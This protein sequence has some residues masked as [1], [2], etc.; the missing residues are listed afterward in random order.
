MNYVLTTPSPR[1]QITLPKK[2]RDKIKRLEP[3]KPLRVSTDGDRIVIEPVNDNPLVV[4]AKYT[5][6][7]SLKLMEKYEKSGKIYWTE[8]DDKHLARLRKKDNKYLHWEI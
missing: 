2:V 8:E 1:W 4:K 7:E 3:G 6:E 5:P